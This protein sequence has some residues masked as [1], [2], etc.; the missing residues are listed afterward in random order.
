MST[1]LNYPVIAGKYRHYKGGT[2][3]VI[4]LAHHT[5]TNE[6]LVIYQSLEFGSVHARPLNQ[7]FDVIENASVENRPKTRRFEQFV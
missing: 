6:L 7:W 4:S 2:Y 1:T 5:E 3:I